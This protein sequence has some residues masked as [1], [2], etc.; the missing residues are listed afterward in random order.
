MPDCLLALPF[1]VRYEI[2]RVFWHTNVPLIGKDIPSRFDWQIYE[3][4]WQMLRK[5]P[6]LQGRR[7]PEKTSE[8]VW[9]ALI[10]GDCSGGHGVTMCG[11]FHYHKSSTSL[12]RF[13][14]EPLRLE[15][16]YRMSRRFGSDRF[17]EISIPDVIVD[18]RG[19]KILQNVG[20]KSKDVIVDW[21]L[22]EMHHLVGRIWK[23]FGQKSIKRRREQKLIIDA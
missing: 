21:M 19:P 9:A 1:Y 8:E 10:V 13:Q 17:I 2:C 14:L 23:P 16:S 4:I 5:C 6:P 12:F 11:S 22:D 7:F 20:R 3:G 18:K 15:E